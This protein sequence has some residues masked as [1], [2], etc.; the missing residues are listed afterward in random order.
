MEIR[1]FK[2]KDFNDICKIFRS[3]LKSQSM[4]EQN[5][6]VSL[7][8]TLSGLGG[9]TYCFFKDDRL[10]G[11]VV[12]QC[13]K[14]FY[15]ETYKT[16]IDFIYLPAEHCIQN[17]VNQIINVINAWADE[18]GY[19]GIAVGDTAFLQAEIKPLLFKILLFS[20]IET[21]WETA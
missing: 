2:I 13:G 14:L 4:S 5:L 17:N 3:S 10:I 6:N 9:H 15:E 11:F 19:K 1:S 21:V 8:N 16:V 7:K 12:L 20:Q 18:R